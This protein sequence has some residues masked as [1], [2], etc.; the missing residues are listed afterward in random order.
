MRGVRMHAEQSN[1]GK[2]LSNCAMCPPID[3]SRSTRYTWNP[4]FAISSADW[5]PAMPPPTTRVVGLIGTLISS[6]AA[7]SIT[8]ETAPDTTALAFAVATALSEC[9]HETCSRIEANSTRY[10]F[11]PAFF[12]AVRNVFS[13][14]CGEQ[15]ATTTRVNPNSL[16]SFV[17]NSCPRLEHMNLYSRAMITPCRPS[18]SAAQFATSTTSTVPAIFEPQ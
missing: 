3:G 13:C 1:V 18:F 17:I 16:I 5:I 8:L 12:A 10:G 4:A 15:A 2:V 7:F 11:N 14:K 6:N 9:T